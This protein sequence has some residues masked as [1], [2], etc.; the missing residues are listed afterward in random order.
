VVKTALGH[1]LSL[2]PLARAASFLT[3]APF[4]A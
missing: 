3:W 2:Q 4:I 1:K